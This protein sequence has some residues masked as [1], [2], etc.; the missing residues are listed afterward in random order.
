LAKTERAGRVEALGVRTPAVAA[1]LAVTR[2]MPDRL[3]TRVGVDTTSPR[4]ECQAVTAERP[5]TSFLED[6]TTGLRTALGPD[7]V[8][9]YLYGSAVSGGF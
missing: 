5:R 6:L 1:G 8:A 3:P 9:V 2:P 4:T 7:L